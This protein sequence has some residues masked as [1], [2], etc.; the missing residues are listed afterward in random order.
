MSLYDIM[1]CGTANKGSLLMTS[2]YILAIVYS[3]Y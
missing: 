3:L 2:K 1:Q